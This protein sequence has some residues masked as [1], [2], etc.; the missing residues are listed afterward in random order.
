VEKKQTELI[1]LKEIPF[2]VFDTET[3]GLSLTS[4]IIE[5][6]AI[7]IFRG[8][9]VDEFSSLINPGISIPPR[10]TSIHGITDEMVKN[11]PPIE[12]V[13]ERFLRFLKDAIL[14]AHNAVFDLRMLAI[15]LERLQM[16]FF[17][18][19]A[20][21]THTLARKYFPELKKYNLPFLVEYWQSPYNGYHRAL[22]DA[23]HTGFIFFRML[24][25]HGLS[26]NRPLSQFWEWAGKPLFVKDCLPQIKESDLT[27][28]KV[29]LIVE[30]INQER[31]LEIIYAN[32]HL[33]FKP[34]LI[35]PILCFRSGKYH[36]VEA[37]CYT[38][39]IV[40]TFRLDRML[41]LKVI[42]T[43]QLQGACTKDMMR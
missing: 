30:A 11:A 2:V 9:I 24:E 37:F 16:P 43:D 18:N 32:G 25:K 42:I 35:R 5:I 10:A 17:H 8:R 6:G 19:P 23:K 36:Y 40:K 39:E 1:P 27:N 21:D 12:F 33:A 3:T 38:D 22:A 29:R 31:D 34:R 20:V 7:K 26:L 28:P 14:V 4:R 13:L 41:K 15:H